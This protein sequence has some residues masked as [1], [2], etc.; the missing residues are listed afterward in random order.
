VLFYFCCGV[1]FIV[2]LVKSSLVSE[3][4][5]LLIKIANEHVSFRPEICTII[6]NLIRINPENM[7]QQRSSEIKRFLIKTLVD[8]IWS[9][10]PNTTKQGPGSDGVAYDVLKTMSTTT[11]FQHKNMFQDEILKATAAPY[12]PGFARALGTFLMSNHVASKNFDEYQNNF[13]RRFVPSCPF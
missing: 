3:L 12:S 1:F 10:H 9:G 8:L 4:I 13:F 6:S 11:N 7:S 2:P 5:T